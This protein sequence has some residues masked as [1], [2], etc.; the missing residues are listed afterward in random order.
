[1]LQAWRGG[2]QILLVFGHQYLSSLASTETSRACLFPGVSSHRAQVIPLRLIRPP[3]AQ[4]SSLSLF[5]FLPLLFSF[6]FWPHHSPCRILVLWPG[7]EPRPQQWKHRVLT[8]GPPGNFLPPSMFHASL[9]PYGAQLGSL[10]PF[11]CY[12][13]TPQFH[14]PG[15]DLGKQKSQSVPDPLSGHN[16]HFGEQVQDSRCSWIHQLIWVFSL[17]SSPNSKLCKVRASRASELFW[18]A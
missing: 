16:V 6:S 9:E 15:W 13:V 12:S 7:I 10:W 8:T 2:D 17:P 5:L 3:Q 18:G 14:K 11:A 4:F 1:M